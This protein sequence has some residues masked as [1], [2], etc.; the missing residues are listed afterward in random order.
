MKSIK[1]D[2]FKNL[3]S[4]KKI[5]LKHN[6]LA[7]ME[8]LLFTVP[9]SLANS[10]EFDVVNVYLEGNAWNCT[11]NLKW[12]AF[13]EAKFEIMDKNRLN[14]TDQKYKGR[15]IVTVMN[16]KL[17]NKIEKTMFNIFHQQ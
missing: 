3:L 14:C 8:R 12:M 1:N 4:I 17:V 13:D 11:K 2:T 6:L 9:A 15:P 10:L 16:Y 7:M 5:D